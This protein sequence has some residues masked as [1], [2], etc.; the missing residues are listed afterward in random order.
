MDTPA[1]RRP[2]KLLIWRTGLDSTGLHEACTYETLAEA[3][4]AAAGFLADDDAYPWIVAEDGEIL[5][6]QW[7]A[8]YLDA[9]PET[10]PEPPQ[11]P[12]PHAGPRPPARERGWLWFL[13]REPVR[14]TSYRL[15][16]AR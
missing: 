16:F 14:R 5:T 11:R 9:N 3:I 6:P 1:M 7:I 15:A 8:T 4:A 13:R 2:A 12:E 10:K